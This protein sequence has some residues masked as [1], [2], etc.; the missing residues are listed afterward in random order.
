[1]AIFTER[2]LEGK[3]PVING[4]GEQTRDFVYAGDVARANL[5][6]LDLEGSHCFNIGTGQET[7]INEIFDILKEITASDC[8]MV[9]GP[10]KQGEQ[11]RS[12]IS[13][14]LVGKY[15]G[16]RPEVSLKEGLVHTVNYF[17]K[18]CQQL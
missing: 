17:K 7:T 14:E 9:H 11:K 5:K 15:I 2:M 1:M 10:A 3:Q 18:K 12:V 4:D 13:P 16:W 8:K 6:A